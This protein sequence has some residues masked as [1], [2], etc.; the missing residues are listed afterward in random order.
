MKL[1]TEY[2][3]RQ[4][5]KM[6]DKYHHILD[7][8]ETEIIS[9]LEPIE[10]PTYEEIDDYARTEAKIKEADYNDTTIGLFAYVEFKIGAKWVIEQIEK[11]KFGIS[12]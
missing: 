8:E 1:Y 10:L 5:I 9:V 3:V 4:A 7:S 6:A 11:Q 12:E 2:Q